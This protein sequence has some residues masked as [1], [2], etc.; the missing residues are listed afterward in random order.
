VRSRRLTACAMARPLTACYSDDM[1]ATFCSQ[2]PPRPLTFFKHVIPL[3]S[4]LHHF[5]L[6]V[7][8]RSLRAVV[9]CLVPVTC[10]GP[11][12][13]QSILC[14]SRCYN[15]VKKGKAV[16]LRSIEAHLGDR[17]Y[18]SCSFL[19]TALEGGEWS[20]SR[21]GRALPPGKEPPVPIV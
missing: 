17:R 10:L 7:L 6:I 13:P 12:T 16:P 1:G 19:T 15:S 11:Y 5:N 2:P 3:P 20:A 9:S 4:S 21:P 14:S 8:E 18:S